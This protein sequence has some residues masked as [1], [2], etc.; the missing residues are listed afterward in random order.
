[1]KGQVK[2]LNIKIPLVWSIRK[3]SGF[4]LEPKHASGI[5]IGGNNAMERR[6]TEKRLEMGSDHLNV[7]DRDRDVDPGGGAPDGRQGR[8]AET[9]AGTSGA[10]QNVR[11]GFLCD[12]CL[13]PMLIAEDHLEINGSDFPV[14]R[15]CA[16]FL[17][18]KEGDHE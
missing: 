2:T 10:D 6:E 7:G 12:I 16:D 9:G 13:R 3:D 4:L 5:S 8:Q 1:M 17:R 14:C 18:G 11:S 15:Q